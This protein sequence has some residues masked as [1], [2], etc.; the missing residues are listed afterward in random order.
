MTLSS[1]SNQ[2]GIALF[3]VL[4]VLL[5]VSL[6]VLVSL[7]SSLLQERMTAGTRDRAMAF[8]NA[9]AA[10]DQAQAA[11]GASRFG[12]GE[13]GL[14]CSSRFDIASALC[15]SHPSLAGSAAPGRGWREAHDLQPQALSAGAP[16]FAMQYM[17]RRESQIELGLGDEPNYGESPGRVEADYYRVLARGS[18]HQA[19]PDRSQVLLQATIVRE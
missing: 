5:L 1:A 4:I 15:W 16:G 8:Q 7:R 17:G 19:A 13:G 2:R 14:D 12:E 9:E 18:D 3:T 11:I 6:L 10:L